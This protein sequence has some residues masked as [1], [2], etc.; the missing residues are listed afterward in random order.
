MKKIALLPAALLML[1]T[2]AGAAHATPSAGRAVNRDFA[3]LSVDGSRA[4]DDI[5]MART[6]LANNDTAGAVKLL[7]DANNALKRAKS[8][9]KVFMKA[10]AQLTP[11][12]KA[13]AGAPAPAA[14]ASTKPVAWLP[15]DGEY[16]VTEDLEPS[17]TK[18]TAVTSA[19]TSLNKG[20]PAQAAQNLQVAAVDV[21]FVLAIAPLDTSASDVYRATN[22]LAGKDTKGADNALQE[23]QN[24]IR[25]VSEDMVGTPDGQ[26]PAGHGKKAANN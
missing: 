9:N 7:T 26:K 8:D 10:E 20:Q 15:V 2:A 19:N 17:S 3:K 18:A 24:S 12:K 13:P 4:F 14:A 5:A 1:G 11:P 16:I 6:A 22:L 21:D 25:F 23:A